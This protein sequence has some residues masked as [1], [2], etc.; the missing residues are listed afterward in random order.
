MK[1]PGFGFAAGE[2]LCPITAAEFPRVAF[3]YPIIFLKNEKGEV[4]VKS[5]I[6]ADLKSAERN[7][8]N[9]PA[10]GHASPLAPTDRVPFDIGILL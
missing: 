8:V 4:G 3:N 5:A 7:R 1:A 9:R 2:T 6:R 10:M